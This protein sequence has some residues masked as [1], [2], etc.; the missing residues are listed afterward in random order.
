MMIYKDSKK[1]GFAVGSNGLTAEKLAAGGVT[2]VVAVVLALMA[3]IFGFGKKKSKKKKKGSILTALILPAVY[4]TAKA[5]IENNNVKV[6]VNDAASEY[7]NALNDDD[8]G[9]EVVDAI[10]IASEEEVYEHI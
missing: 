6:T 5:A 10:P 4:K 9:I 1:G 3:L 8:G 7:L 2:A